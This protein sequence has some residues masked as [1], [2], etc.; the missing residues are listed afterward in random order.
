MDWLSD[1]THVLA[2]N[3]VATAVRAT[4]SLIAIVDAQHGF[5]A[6]QK[7]GSIG[8]DFFS[9]RIEDCLPCCYREIEQHIA[10]KN[11]VA[12]RDR[13][14][15]IVEIQLPKFNQPA[16][17]LRDTPLTLKRSKVFF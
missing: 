8:A 9:H 15:E 11:N 5:S 6:A 1:K 10:E 2:F 12:R 7:E 16:A 14:P 4:Q 3:A 17:V 13:R